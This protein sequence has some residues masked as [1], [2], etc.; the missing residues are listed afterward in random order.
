[1]A[2]G[3]GRLFD[4][5]PLVTLRGLIS[6]YAPDVVHAW[7]RSAIR[8]GAL[9]G[10]KGR[11]IASPCL[12]PDF[13]RSWLRR[14]DGWLLRRASHVVAFGE[15]EA[16]RCRKLGYSGNLLVVR[17]AVKLE[18]AVGVPRQDRFIL[19][20]GRLEPEKGFADAVWAHD[21]LRYVH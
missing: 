13:Q 7:G 12:P 15:V 8:L 5:K 16:E 20:I 17:P 2:P 21:I 18:E 9:S 1:D 11:L 4:L 6:E 14:I 19:C 10:F 3:R